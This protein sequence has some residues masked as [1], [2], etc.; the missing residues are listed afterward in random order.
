MWADAIDHEIQRCQMELR[1]LQAARLSDWHRR[2]GAAA[3][4]GGGA[5]CIDEPGSR[6]SKSDREWK[7]HFKQDGVVGATDLAHRF[8]DW[9]GLSQL[10]RDYSR[11]P[12]SVFRDPVSNQVN[13]L[14]VQNPIDPADVVCVIPRRVRLVDKRVRHAAC[15]ICRREDLRTDVKAAAEIAD[16]NSTLLRRLART[17]SLTFEIG[18]DEPADETPSVSNEPYDMAG[19][20]GLGTNMRVL[21]LNRP[22]QL[23]AFL[24]SFN[25]KRFQPPSQPASSLWGRVR[26]SLRRP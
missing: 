3:G 21:V 20:L 18:P 12:V 23:L 17:G 2:L 5:A 7:L 22:L 25:W 4:Q 8:P 13:V 11:C 16:A 1:Q 10:I 15:I 6:P 26:E 24:N 9:M 19:E 14:E